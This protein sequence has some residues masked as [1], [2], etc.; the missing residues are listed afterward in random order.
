MQQCHSDSIG[1]LMYMGTMALKKY[2]ESRL[3]P[4]GLTAEQFQVLKNL[5][6]NGGLPQ[7]VV[8][9]AVS[10]SPANITRILDRLEKKDY[11]E[12]RDNPNDRRSSLVYLTNAGRDLMDKLLIELADLEEQVTKGI[13]AGN[14]AIMRNSL[15]QV[16]KNLDS[17]NNDGGTQE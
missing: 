2:L 6:M 9:E 1:R 15:L 12:R 16:L 10:K 7:S 17:Y 14:L 11:L 3:R 13:P 4:Y 8:G 5:S